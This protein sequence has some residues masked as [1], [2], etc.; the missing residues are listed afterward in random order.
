MIDANIGYIRITT[1][2]ATTHKEFVEKLTELQGKG[3]KKL[4]IDLRGN[5]GG[6]LQAATSIADELISGDKLLSLH[7]RPCLR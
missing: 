7:Q 1:F 5:P 3:M 2:S 6:Y 4:I